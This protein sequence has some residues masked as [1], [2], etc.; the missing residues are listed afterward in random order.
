MNDAD[1]A[2][3][4]MYIQITGLSVPESQGVS[5]VAQIKRQRRSLERMLGYPLE[6]SA[7]NDNQYTEIG[8]TSID[9]PCG[10]IDTD[11]LLDPDAVVYAYRL[12]TY[13]KHDTY[14]HIDPASAVHK[15]KLVKGGVT[16]KTLDSDFYRLDYKNGFIKYI[17]QCQCWCTCSGDCG[18]VQ[19]AV[20]ASWLW[21]DDDNIPSELEDL[22]MDMV[23]Y[24]S[25]RKK[26]IKSETLGPHSYTKFG[27]SAPE[28]LAEN[29]AI[30]NKYIGGN[31]S[32]NRTITL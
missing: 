1:T 12:F 16:V 30:I 13:N 22:W 21:P 17:E 8:K 24:Y 5:V 3:L 23:T 19:L 10:S 15:V 7:V 14:L 20:D 4:N 26:D 2:L 28:S 29:V 27:N 32:L 25:D 6:E 31:G 18:C 11:N 9:C